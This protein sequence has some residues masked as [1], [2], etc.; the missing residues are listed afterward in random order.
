MTSIL[1]SYRGA[2]ARYRGVLSVSYIKELK[3]QFDRLANIAQASII[4][5]SGNNGG[6]PQLRFIHYNDVYHVEPGSRDPVGG[7]ARF[8]TQCQY[9]R[10]DESFRDLPEVVTL[11]SGDA[12]NPSLESSVTKGSCLDDWCLALTI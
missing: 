8:Q 1:S 7:I 10:Y 6:P 2:V 11:F 12:F 5:D 4:Y 3:S 9:Y